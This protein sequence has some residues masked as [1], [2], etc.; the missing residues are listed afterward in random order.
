MDIQAADTYLPSVGPYQGLLRTKR[1]SAVEK[2]V[3]M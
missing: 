3:V 1:V 2:E